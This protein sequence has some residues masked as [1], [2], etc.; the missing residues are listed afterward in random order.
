MIKMGTY[1][2]GLHTD[3]AKYGKF[4]KFKL[5]YKATTATQ[6]SARITVT[7]TLKYVGQ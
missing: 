2:T 6:T 5:A 4:L 7:V 3:R 1:G